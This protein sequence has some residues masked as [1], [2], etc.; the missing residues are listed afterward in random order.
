VTYIR[1]ASQYSYLKPWFLYG[2]ALALLIYRS[3]KKTRTIEEDV[4]VLSAFLYLMSL[5]VFGNAADARLV[6]YTTTT[7]SIVIFISMKSMI[8]WIS[9]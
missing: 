7:L 3:W 1:T 2:M 9:K 6:F 8:N 5:I 4:L